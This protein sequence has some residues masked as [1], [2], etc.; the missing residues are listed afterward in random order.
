M[1]RSNLLLGAK[2]MLSHGGISIV[3]LTMKLT[4]TD[5]QDLKDAL[6]DLLEDVEKKLQLGRDPILLH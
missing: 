4:T 1:I 5:R 3:Q 6:E 2:K